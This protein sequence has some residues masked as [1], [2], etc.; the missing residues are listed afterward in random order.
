MSFFKAFQTQSMIFLFS[1]VFFLF[2]LLQNEAR[3]GGWDF[4]LSQVYCIT[5]HTSIQYYVHGFNAMFYTSSNHGG[6]PFIKTK[7]HVHSQLLKLL[8]YKSF[9][10]LKN[11]PIHVQLQCYKYKYQIQIHKSFIRYSHYHKCTNIFLNNNH[12]M[13]YA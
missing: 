9:V 12:C 6:A 2:T 4:S 11:L 1:E 5:E 8:I 7:N 10:L 3:L 13:S